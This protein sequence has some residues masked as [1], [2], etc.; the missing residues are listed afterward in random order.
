MMLYA[1][2]L[3]LFIIISLIFLED[4]LGDYKKYVYW[5]FCI[6][7][8]LFTA[9]RPIGFDPDSVAYESMFLDNEDDSFFLIDPSYIFLVNIFRAFTDDIH[10][11]FLFYAII[12]ISIKFYAL[13]QLSPLFF[14][15]LIIYFGNYYILHDYIQIRAA[16][17]SA[18]L[19][20]AIKPISEGKKKKAFVYLLIAN[21]FHSS[22][23][24][25]YPILLFSNNISKIWKY[26]LIAIT[27]IG[28]ILFLLHLDFITVLPIPYIQEK[29]EM[30]RVMTEVGAYDELTLKQPFIWIHYA[31]IL[32]S[33]YF[34]DTIRKNCP[35]LPLLLKITACS[36]FCYFSFSSVPV[37]AVRLRELLSIVEIALLPG[38][39]YTIRPQYFGKIAVCAIGVIELVFT[40]FIWK[41]LDFSVI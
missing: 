9:F 23:L 11:L 13:R 22:T 31:A 34:Y 24:A 37:V 25:L 36:L 28:A 20:L 40:L 14:L 5:G 39:C 26:I 7:L 3:L 19:L 29:I 8:I 1:F 21:V 6:I 2:I 12:G 38:I 4:Y 10:F 17:A 41:H 35:T 16:I 18:M 30:Y 33:L 27:P 32:Y 15:P